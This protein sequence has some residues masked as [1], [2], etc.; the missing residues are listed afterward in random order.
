MADSDYLWNRGAESFAAAWDAVLGTAGLPLGRG[1]RKV[2]LPD[3]AHRIEQG[4]MQ[5]VLH[6][7]AFLGV[8]RKPDNSALLALIARL[9][10]AGAR[11]RQA[12]EGHNI[13]SGKECQPTCPTGP[14]AAIV[15]IHVA[16]V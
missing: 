2:T 15:K 13:N 16:S 12:A 1:P 9:D 14:D 10:R 5:P 11:G 4:L 7:K 3:L 8:V 6:R